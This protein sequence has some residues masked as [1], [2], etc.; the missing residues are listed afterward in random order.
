[1]LTLLTFQNS[2]QRICLW[3]F[4]TDL[5]NTWNSQNTPLWGNLDVALLLS[6]IST[7]QIY[8]PCVET[9][10]LILV[11]T[12]LI[13]VTESLDLMICVVK[14]HRTCCYNCTSRDESEV[15]DTEG[16]QWGCDWRKGLDVDLSCLT[17]T[18]YIF[19]CYNM[20]SWIIHPGKGW[21]DTRRNKICVEHKLLYHVRRR[22]LE[23][24]NQHTNNDLGN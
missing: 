21:L 19:K 13:P 14:Q 24:L 16:E 15:L 11:F 4:Y 22:Y 1:M 18:V 23:H 10:L 12:Q 3:R 6:D 5:F 8:C 7:I 2:K 9:I 17:V 20:V